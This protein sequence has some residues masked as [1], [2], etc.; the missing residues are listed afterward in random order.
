VNLYEQTILWIVC[1]KKEE[2]NGAASRA[3]ACG[4]LA[5][6]ALR[7]NREAILTEGQLLSPAFI[8]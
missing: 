4:W 8:F 5:S 7:Q 2:L 3:P 1:D 6:R